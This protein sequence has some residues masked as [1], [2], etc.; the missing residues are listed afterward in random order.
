MAVGVGVPRHQRPPVG[1]GGEVRVV[2]VAADRRLVVVVGRRGRQAG[3]HPRAERPV[4]GLVDRAA[5]HRRGDRAGVGLRAVR[6]DLARLQDPAR[7]AVGRERGVDLLL[8]IGRL[9]RAI[10]APEDADPARGVVDHGGVGEAGPPALDRRRRADRPARRDRRVQ[11]VLGVRPGPVVPGEVQDPVGG[12]GE[13]DLVDARPVRHRHPLPRRGIGRRR[14]DPRGKDGGEQGG[15]ELHR[16]TLQAGHRA[17]RES[18]GWLREA[19]SVS[20]RS[21]G[22]P[23]RS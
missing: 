3:V 11:Q 17:H 9:R 15:G 10:A 4:P 20:F 21:R 19:G 22:F 8:R 14:R 12:P 13:A 18:R 16:P 7:A 6:V 5:A 2:A 1:V 23:E